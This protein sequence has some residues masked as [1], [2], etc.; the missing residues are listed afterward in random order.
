MLWI[1]VKIYISLTVVFLL[2]HKVK[3]IHAF[4]KMREDMVKQLIHHY[5]ITDERV[6]NSMRS[7]PRHLFV[8]KSTERHAYDD[9]PLPIGYGQTI[10]QPYIVALMTAVAQIKPSDK[11]LEIGT[12]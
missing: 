4:E 12:G 3:M 10:S 6:L 11:V 9:N 2:I 7:V 8:D 5:R 1:G